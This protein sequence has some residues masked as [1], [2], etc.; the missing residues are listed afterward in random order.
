MAVSHIAETLGSATSSS[1]VKARS[2]DIQADSN[3]F[4]GTFVVQR[5]LDATTGWV[6][7]TSTDGTPYEFT[8]AGCDIVAEAAGRCKWRVTVTAYT[9]GSIDVSMKRGDDTV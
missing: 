6:T 2:V 5:K 7:A 9:S 4:V 8:D 1:E 3:S